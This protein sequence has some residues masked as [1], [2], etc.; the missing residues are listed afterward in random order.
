MSSKQYYH[1]DC[2]YFNSS[3]ATLPSSPSW[4]WKRAESWIVWCSQ[5]GFLHFPGI[6]FSTSSNYLFMDN[7]FNTF[8]IFFKIW[9]S[10]AGS[11]HFPAT[12]FL[13][14][15]NIFLTT[16]FEIQF[17]YLF[18]KIWCSRTESLY[19]PKKNISLLQ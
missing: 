10:L 17:E 5:A 2:S 15:S 8:W 1:K 16:Y 6:I 9:C 11:L 18:F 3:S 12:I 19:F 7:F 13:T 14:C 4:K